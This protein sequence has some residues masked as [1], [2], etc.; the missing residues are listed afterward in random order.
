MSCDLVIRPF[1]AADLPR[2]HEIREAAFKPIFQSFRDIV[3]DDIAQPAFATAEAEQAAH[4]E[5][6]CQPDSSSKVFVARVESDIVGFVA[7]SLDEEK[8]IG[9]IGLN[10]VHPSYA[11]RGVGTRLYEFAIDIM[12]DAGMVVATV[13]TGADPSHAPARRAYEKAGFGKGIPSVW[14]YKL[15]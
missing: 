11:G 10:A 3:G 1:E 12:R 6:L 14:L 5:A 13:G 7:L 2:L 8:K 9:E 15:L 4:L